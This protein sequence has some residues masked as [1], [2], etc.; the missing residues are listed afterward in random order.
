MSVSE[1]TALL[2]QSDPARVLSSVESLCRSLAGKPYLLSSSSFYPAFGLLLHR[3]L[4]V[5]FSNTVP[6]LVLAL[7]RAWDVLRP[8]GS[9]F[10]LLFAHT[11]FPPTY[12]LTLD[13][14]PQHCRD[15]LH[16]PA[17]ASASSSA[18]H[19]AALSASALPGCPG[20]LALLRSS[21]HPSS[22]C[23]QL[24]IHHYTFFS[25]ALFLTTDLPAG[26]ALLHSQ[27]LASV[28]SGASASAGIVGS[29]HRQASAH[30]G[31]SNSD[32]CYNAYHSL[33][34]QYLPLFLP[35]AT[36]ASAGARAVSVPSRSLYGASLAAILAEVWMGTAAAHSS[37]LSP[38]ALL[39]TGASS[40]GAANGLSAH[41]SL[42]SP[43]APQSQHPSSSPSARAVRPESLQG[44]GQSTAV[45]FS[46]PSLRV[47]KCVAL[48]VSHLL[49]APPPSATAGKSQP[50]I[51]AQSSPWGL[52]VSSV[53]VCVFRFL[54]SCLLH[55]PSAYDER[56]QS[57]VLVW[58]SVLDAAVQPNSPSAATLHTA[59][60]FC[61]VLLVD[62]LHALLDTDIGR[63]GSAMRARCLEHCVRLMARLHSARAEL[64]R[65]EQLLL[66]GGA[67]A[68]RKG[69]S[70]GTRHS[71]S[72]LLKS[73]LGSRSSAQAETDV[74]RGNFMRFTAQPPDEQHV[75]RLFT[76][77]ARSSTNALS[78]VQ[79]LVVQV[80]RYLTPSSVRQGL[81]PLSLSQTA[82]PAAASGVLAGRSSAQLLQSSSAFRSQLIAEAQQFERFASLAQQ[83]FE[84]PDEA[85]DDSVSSE[86]S[87]R[88]DDSGRSASPSGS[89][90]WSGSGGTNPSAASSPRSLSPQR[91]HSDPYQ[92]LSLAG[93]QQLARGTALC[94]R[95]ANSLRFVGSEWERPVNSHECAAAVRLMHRLHTALSGGDTQ[96]TPMHAVIAQLPLRTFARW[97]VLGAV[98]CGLLFALLVV[99]AVVS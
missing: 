47:L 90:R 81:A 31:G 75:A 1:L 40:N 33:L 4:S 85:G 89:Q 56:L 54:R 27:P 96:H 78:G 83:M 77:P 2:S 22:D 88:Q 74:I 48:L 98:L 18:S 8:S 80:V 28:S 11:A 41:S 44:G 63:E 46:F 72:L 35:S 82:G 93:R 68:A 37:A 12:P 24:S 39:H 42:P 16:S 66:G 30:A 34:Q 73:A 84:L 19:L 10:E 59:F 38:S 86:V 61:S 65:V 13:R 23:L 99:A 92:R 50:P 67:E 53:D 14:L 5:S 69:A 55:P 52:S 7:P 25:L 79:Q 57:V 62:F 15:F 26:A 9:L 43:F 76:R 21:F 58:L 45:S 94:S 29:N 51:S 91:V 71:A 49:S 3:L 70:G 64:E 6:P 97:D 95:Q 17:F 32:V 87:G 36:A 20:L 60:A